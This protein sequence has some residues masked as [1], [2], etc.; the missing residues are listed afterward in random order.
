MIY[1]F[2]A[3]PLGDLPSKI[4]LNLFFLHVLTYKTGVL[5]II[6]LPTTI[7]TCAFSH[8]QAVLPPQWR[9]LQPNSVLTLSTWRW[10][11]IPGVKGSVLTGLPIRCQRQVEVVTHASYLL[12]I[13][14]KFSRPP[15]WGLINLLEKL[16]E[17]RETFTCIC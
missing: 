1:K 16:T 8:H 4:L 6:P 10:H 11:Q 3:H 14:H 17:L 7:T 9:V 2:I 13:N 15:S 12:A 5:R